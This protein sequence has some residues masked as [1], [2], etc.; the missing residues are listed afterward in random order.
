MARDQRLSAEENTL[1]TK[2]MLLGAQTALPIALSGLELCRIIGVIYKDT[3]NLNLLTQPVRDAIVPEKNYYETD[4]QWF[5]E[6]YLLDDTDYILLFL[7]AK[8]EISDF[9]T[10]L[11]CITEVHKRRK[12]YARILKSQPIPTMVQVSPRS[13]LEFGGL[14]TDAL[15]SWLTWKKWFYDID[16]RSAQESG[17]LFEPILAAALGGEPASGKNSPISRTDDP[18]KRRQVDCVL[19]RA[20]GVGCAYEFKLR[21]TIAASGQGRFKEEIAFATDCL[22]S[23]YVPILLVLD[24]TPNPRM[25]ELAAAFRAAG[26]EAH[27]GNDA[28]EH[29]ETEA[30]ETMARFIEQYV[31][32]PIRSITGFE[33]Q[34]MDLSARRTDNGDIE[35]QLGEVKKLIARLENPA[36]ATDDEEDL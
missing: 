3:D 25:A 27:I 22:N 18:T 7:Q 31:R 32:V 2:T 19:A 5:E 4:L 36:L 12:K 14:Q 24:P 1:L 15:A 26:G 9:I 34:L 17:Y 20:D 16:N 23:Q 33:N 29:L 11:R 13:L 6:N 30:G 8:Q 28:W 10:Y 21:V 35:I